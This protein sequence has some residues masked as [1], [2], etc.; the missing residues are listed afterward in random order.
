VNDGG[1]MFTLFLYC[2]LLAI[3]RLCNL[4]QLLPEV[5]KRAQEQWDEMEARLFELLDPLQG[6]G[7]SR[8]DL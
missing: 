1:N 6:V 7:T 4:K 5:W 2:P 8:G 3:A